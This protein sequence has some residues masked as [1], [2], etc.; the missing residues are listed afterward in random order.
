MAED[1]G[2]D[3]TASPH[4]GSPLLAATAAGDS[5]LPVLM[6]PDKRLQVFVALASSFSL[7]S[8]SIYLSIFYLCRLIGIRWVA[9]S[10]G[11][12]LC[13]KATKEAEEE[14]EEV[15]TALAPRLCSGRPG[16]LSH[17]AQLTTKSHNHHLL[18]RND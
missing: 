10:P 17:T 14:Q 4:G 13:T 1:A 12:T 5:T 9:S 6:S 11:P 2:S 18:I 16:L 8:L 3:A 15:A 7:F